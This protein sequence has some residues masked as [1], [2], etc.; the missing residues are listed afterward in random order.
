MTIMHLEL[1]LLLL[2]LLTA[3]IAA[4]G[5]APIWASV[6]LLCVACLIRMAR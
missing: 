2:A 1:L 3:I 4:M 5:R 6:L